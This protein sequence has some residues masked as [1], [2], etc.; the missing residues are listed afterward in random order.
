M[1]RLRKVTTVP[2]FAALM[3]FLSLALLALAGCASKPKDTPKPPP[4]ESDIRARF[5]VETSRKALDS[6]SDEGLRR[7]VD[8]QL[9]ERAER[10]A[11]RRLV[12]ESVRLGETIN[13]G[14][15]QSMQRV[16][17]LY[18]EYDDAAFTTFLEGIELIGGRTRSALRVV[19]GGSGKGFAEIAEVELNRAVLR[20]FLVEEGKDQPCCPS[21]EASTAYYL[22]GF[23]LEPAR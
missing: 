21:R 12:V 19:V 20:V 3:A 4:T 2:T 14:G 15:G 5:N 6:L 1:R 22:T 9:A 7:A 11:R 10:A 18:H 23:S 17:A 13:I 8:R 16:F